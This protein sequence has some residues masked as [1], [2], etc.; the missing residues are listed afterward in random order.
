MNAEISTQMQVWPAVLSKQ[1]DGS[2]LVTFP[3]IPEALNEGENAT[4]AMSRA[5]DCLVSA[6]GGYINRQ[7]TIPQPALLR[8]RHSVVLP[9][10]TA[11]KVELH[12]VMQK[13]EI[14]N[15]GLA[16]M[17][18]VSEEVV[19]LLTDLDHHSHIEEVET[20]L[21]TLGQQSAA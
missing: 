2:T 5:R 17:L 6:L 10:L 11:A 13:Q 3:D 21:L 9:E 4:E 14:G 19:Q 1:L 8:G 7:R 16:A 12:N 20:A 15:S 18:S